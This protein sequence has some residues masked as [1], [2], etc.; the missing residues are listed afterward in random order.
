[1]KRPAPPTITS[2]PELLVRVKFKVM[3]LPATTVNGP[4]LSR[5]SAMPLAEAGRGARKTPI[6]KRLNNP[7]TK[8]IGAIFSVNLSF[9]AGFLRVTRGTRDANLLRPSCFILYSL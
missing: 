9:L 7:I 5:V 8:R 1:M 3:E 6:T 2:S 4:M